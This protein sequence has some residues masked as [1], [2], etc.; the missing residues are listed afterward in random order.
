MKQENLIKKNKNFF[1]SVADHYDNKLLKSWF[2]KAL[3]KTIELIDIKENSRILDLGCGTGNLLKILEDENK[4]L[5]LFGIDISEKMLK[6]AAAKLKKSKLIL[7]SAENINFKENF[8]DIVFSTEAFHHFSNY[9]L[10]MKNIHKILK[11]DGKLIV[12]DVDFGFI[13]NKIFHFI[14]PGNNKMHSPY[15]FK[16]LFKQ[17]GFD[18]IRQKRI[19]LFFILTIG[20]VEK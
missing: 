19:N 4:N 12:L 11:K 17:Y 15:E 13:L 10:I 5:M 9:N 8:L 1:N 20:E 2:L 14:E 6:I 3:Q 18:N 16:K 7:N